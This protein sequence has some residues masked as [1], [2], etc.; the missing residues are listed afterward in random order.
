MSLSIEKI[1]EGRMTPNVLV[2]RYTPGGYGTFDREVMTL[3]GSQ[4]GDPITLTEIRD[5]YFKND[6]AEENSGYSSS[7]A[8]D[9][10]QEVENNRHINSLSMGYFQKVTS[11]FFK[12]L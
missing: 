9:L 7:A 10:R 1:L 4:I 11:P 3:G 5:L 2:P 12:T 8:A 6:E